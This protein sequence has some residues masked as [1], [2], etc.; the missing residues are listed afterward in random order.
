MVNVMDTVLSWTIK[1]GLILMFGIIGIVV[2][3]F[4]LSLFGI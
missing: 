2:L 1:I 4:V 3:L